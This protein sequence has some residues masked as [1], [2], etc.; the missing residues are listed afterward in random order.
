[1]KS[2]FCCSIV[3]ILLL[4]IACPSVAQ[5]INDSEVRNLLRE[6]V[7]Q[8]QHGS[9][10]VTGI[11]DEKG[12]RVIGYGHLNRSG[13]PEANGNTVFEIGS[14]TKAFTGVVL[15]DLVVRKEV[16]LDDPVAEFLPKS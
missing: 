2:A 10:I 15:A 13:G 9:C 16:S 4:T 3:A 11:L 6:R 8:L 7:D 5:G 14:I 12:S 1:M